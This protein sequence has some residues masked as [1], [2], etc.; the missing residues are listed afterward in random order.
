MFAH[1]TRELQT[2]PDLRCTK[3]CIRLVE[4]GACGDKDCTFAHDVGELRTHSAFHKTK[5]CRFFQKGYCALGSQCNFA[6]SHDELQEVEANE[7]EVQGDVTALSAEVSCAIEA[8]LKPPPGLGEDDRVSSVPIYR[9]SQLPEGNPAYVPLPGSYSA[10]PIPYVYN[11]AQDMHMASLLSAH[12]NLTKMWRPDAACGLYGEIEVTQADDLWQ[13]KHA[14]MGEEQ[15]QCIR[16]VRTS[17]TTLCSLGDTAEQEHSG[18]Q[19]TE[20]LLC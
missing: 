1:N 19:Q 16:S 9:K 8:P 18:F 10:N 14:S 7:G 20:N 17:E 11:C 2:P 15:P 13:M 3:L 5:L 4:T 6:H 12:G